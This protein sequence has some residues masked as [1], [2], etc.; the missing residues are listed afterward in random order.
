ME[1]D[2]VF[3]FKEDEFESTDFNAAQFVARY[4]RVT[5]LEDLRQQLRKC[6]EGLKKQLYSILNRDYQ[7][8]INIASKLEGVD[9]RIDQ[10]R[11][12]LIDLRLDV[13][14]VHDGLVSIFFESTEN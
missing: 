12:P 13:S 9:S 2:I 6:C 3:I 4:R 5:S 10:L 8:F 11:R 1:E 7:D 14:A